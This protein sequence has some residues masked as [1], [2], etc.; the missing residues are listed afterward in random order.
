MIRSS[1]CW[2]CRKTSLK[3]I[4]PDVTTNEESVVSF[5]EELGGVCVSVLVLVEYHLCCS[6]LWFVCLFVCFCYD[7]QYFPPPPPPHHVCLCSV[8]V[9]GVEEEEE[10]ASKDGTFTFHLMFVSFFKVA[11]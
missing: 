8:V 9:S 5:E 1:C 7:F 6:S 2:F 11:K 3:T 4:Q 10:Q